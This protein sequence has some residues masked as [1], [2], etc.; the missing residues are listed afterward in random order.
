MI[1]KPLDINQF[2]EATGNRYPEIY[3]V[4]DYYTNKGY[5][6][7]SEIGVFLP[8]IRLSGTI[9]LLCYRPTDFVILD[10]KTG[11]PEINLNNV[12]YGL[13]MQLPVYLYLANNSKK[14]NIIV[15][16]V[17]L[18]LAAIITIITPI[19]Y[20]IF[21]IFSAQNIVFAIDLQTQKI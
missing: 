11:N 12:I 15:T 18:A 19:T 4:F 8:H 5:V 13:D 17:I 14:L 10:Y 16:S 1:P 21:K 7:Y 2:I 3:R 6:I 9:D 20:K